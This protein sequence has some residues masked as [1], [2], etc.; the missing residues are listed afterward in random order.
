MPLKSLALAGAL[1]VAALP[2]LAVDQNV[3]LSPSGTGSFS[4]AFDA[5]H[6][7]SGLFVDS[8]VFSLPSGSAGL[9]GNVA[10]TFAAL[11]GDI[12]LVVA[13]LDAA[14]GAY[15][16]SPPDPASIAIPS[17]LSL[18]NATAPLTLTVLGFAGDPFADATPLTASYSGRIAFTAVAAIAEPETYALMLAGLAG[19]GWAARRRG[20][21]RRDRSGSEPA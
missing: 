3:V 21:A 19:V 18:M 13:T 16:A 6:L 14:N 12:S 8:F 20:Q 2:C 11:S 1:A 15:T 7:Q 9:L 5:T 17:T 4:A 10:L